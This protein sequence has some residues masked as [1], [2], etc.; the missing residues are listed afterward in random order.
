MDHVSAQTAFR[1]VQATLR[2]KGWAAQFL[3]STPKF[4]S[5]TSIF[6]AFDF[7]LKRAHFITRAKAEPC[8]SS[9]ANAQNSINAHSRAR[10]KY[11]E[12]QIQTISFNFAFG[13]RTF[14]SFNSFALLRQNCC[15]GVRILCCAAKQ[16]ERIFQPQ[17]AKQ[18][19]RATAPEYAAKTATL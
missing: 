3:H 19:E 4:I 6:F 18:H 13:I 16:Y 5:F 17:N 12:T 10:P 1:N 9:T 11:F 2:S 15:G 14:I 8:I 7:L